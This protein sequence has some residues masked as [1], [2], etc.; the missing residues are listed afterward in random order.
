[1]KFQRNIIK[2]IDRNWTSNDWSFEGGI[3]RS[4]GKSTKK[5]KKVWQNKYINENQSMKMIL[6][7]EVQSWFFGKFCN[8][9]NPQ[10][11]NKQNT[12]STSNFNFPANQFQRVCTI[13]SAHCAGS[14]TK[15]A[16]CTAKRCFAGGNHYALWFHFH[17]NIQ[18]RWPPPA[19]NY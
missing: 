11:I 1:M 9:F 18:R 16:K 6:R 14:P 10:N 17:L 8:F 5:I 19:G 2:C 15:N 4:N 3:Y 7:I 12:I 13:S